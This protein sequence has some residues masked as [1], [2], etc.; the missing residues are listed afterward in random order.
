MKELPS[1]ESAGVFEKKQRRTRFITLILLMLGVYVLA[2]YIVLPLV[3]HGYEKRHPALDDAPDITHTASAIHNG[4][5]G[6]EII[7]SINR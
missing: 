3:W 7:N 6:I 2:A 1:T 4:K 5:V